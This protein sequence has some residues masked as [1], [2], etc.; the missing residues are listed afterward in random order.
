MEYCKEWQV[1]RPA[2][3]GLCVLYVWIQAMHSVFQVPVLPLIVLCLL[4]DRVR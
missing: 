3:A 2:S 1:K 4:P